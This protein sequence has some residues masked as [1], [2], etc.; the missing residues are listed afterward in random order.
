MINWILQ[1]IVILMGYT[2]TNFRTSFT[3]TEFLCALILMMGCTF[4]SGA[5]IGST[6]NGT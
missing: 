2:L 5:R 6:S 4:V 1:M 3:H